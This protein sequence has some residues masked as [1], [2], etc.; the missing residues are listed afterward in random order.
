M[1]TKIGLCGIFIL[2]T[3]YSVTSFSA[4]ESVSFRTYLTNEVINDQP[5]QSTVTEFGCTD[6]IY[7]VVEAAGLSE[8]KHEL[9]VKWFNPVD[10]QQ[11]LTNYG[12]DAFSYTRVWAWLQLSGPP[13]AVLGQMFDPSFGMEEFI[14][15][16]HAKV[17]IDKSEISNL[18]F[19][20]LC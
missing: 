16:W 11:E 5:G 18:G 6:R 15:E 3:L 19:N 13:G 1:I 20:V 14:G 7:L 17:L 12:F 9:T 10:D 2:S 8:Q 4:D